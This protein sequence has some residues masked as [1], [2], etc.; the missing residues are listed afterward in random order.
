M[1]LF[2]MGGSGDSES[3][4]VRAQ[5]IGHCANRLNPV[6]QSL[7]RTIN[8]AQTRRQQGIQEN[9]HPPSQSHTQIEP[10]THTY[11]CT[12]IDA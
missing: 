2:T 7:K 1:V 10:H 3:A 12:C 6:M 11:T 8:E 5:S 4:E 9:S